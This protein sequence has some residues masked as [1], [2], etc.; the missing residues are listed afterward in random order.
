MTTLRALSPRFLAAVLALV[1]TTLVAGHARAQINV[2][3][4]EL[5]DVEV[6]E[7]LGS[8]L[9]L[10]TTFKDHH[11]KVVRLGDYFDGKRPVAVVFVYHTCPM[12][13]SLVLDAAEK[14]MRELSWSI[15]KEYDVLAISIDP[16]DTPAT[17]GRKRG[18]VA[19]AYGR[20]LPE[21][22]ADGGLHFLVG[23]AANVAKVT[24]A[25]GFRYRYDER[26]GQY[27]HPAAL[28]LTTPAGILARYL[29]GIEFKPADL[30]LGLLEASEGRSVSSVEKLLL[31]CYHYDPQGKRYALVAMNVMRVGG[32]ATAVAL[33]GLLAVLWLREKRKSAEDRA[34]SNLPE[35][36][37]SPSLLADFDET[38]SR[39]RTPLPRPSP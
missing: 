33:G 18:E 23:D 38:P 24:E 15:G 25:I 13:C 21:D 34:Y 14:G 19:R 36:L 35:D 12:L 30:R 11:D 10:D 39:S 37:S 6:V 17:A 27:A 4:K 7:H 16:K 5:E 29:Y 31:Y 1:A 22:R 32:A 8:S 28:Y 9:P 26:Q 3:P 2:T 20:Q